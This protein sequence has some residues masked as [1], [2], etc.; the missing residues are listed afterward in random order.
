MT[1]QLAPV[2]RT[3]FVRCTP[4]RAFT[5][6]TDEMSQWWPLHGHSVFLSDAASVT[7]EDGRLVERSTTGE[8]N[9]WGTVLSW[10]P[11]HSFAITWHPGVNK[12]TDTVLSV[13]FRAED[14]GT[15]VHLEHAGWEAF[16]DKALERRASYDNASGWNAV[17][18][19]FTDLFEVG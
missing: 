5:A 4:E 10:E 16:G 6:F 14:G 3:A 7:F 12:G 13:S 9:E 15:R 8:E 1:T 17:L 2:M 19:C 11:P 18:A